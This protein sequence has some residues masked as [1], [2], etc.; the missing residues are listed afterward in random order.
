MT[1]VSSETRTVVMEREFPY[2]P[3]KIWRA[4]TQPHLIAEWLMKTDFQPVQDHRF[5]LSADWGAVDCRV[6]EIESE[7]ALTYTWDALGLESVVA[8][9]LTQTPAGTLLRMEQTGFKPGQEQAYNGAKFG[10]PRFFGAL[11]DLL[12]RID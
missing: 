10:W 7:R 4:L 8:W 6:L 1:E 2:P 9:T 3:A 11:E 12:A 5:T